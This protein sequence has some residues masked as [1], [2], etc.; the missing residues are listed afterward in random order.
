MLHIN[1]LR[2]APIMESQLTV[3]EWK[4][5]ETFFF[6]EFPEFVFRNH[7]A[8]AKRKFSERKKLLDET[9]PEP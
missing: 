1:L 3:E 8:S 4:E 5:Y 6:N 2:D 9:N 7:K